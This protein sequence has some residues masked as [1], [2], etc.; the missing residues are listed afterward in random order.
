MDKRPKKTFWLMDWSLTVRNDETTQQI[1]FVCVCVGGKLFCMRSDK[2]E[3]KMKIK[4]IGAIEEVLLNWKISRNC[5]ECCPKSRKGSTENGDK[6]EKQTRIR[7][8]GGSGA[9]EETRRH[10]R[11]RPLVHF[12]WTNPSGFQASYK[13]THIYRLRWS[14]RLSS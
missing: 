5:T 8:S 6:A 10:P 7:S 13:A 2:F 12:H 3:I 1:F 11:R 9:Q 14:S 4:L